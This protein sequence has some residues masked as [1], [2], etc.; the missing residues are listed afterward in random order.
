MTHPLLIPPHESEPK[1][2]ADSPPSAPSAPKPASGTSEPAEAWDRVRVIQSLA[3]AAARSREAEVDQFALIAAAADVYAWVDNAEEA[4][5]VYGG[6]SPRAIHGERLWQFGA[7]GTPEVAE[8]ITFE[9]GPAL[10]TSPESAATLIADVLDL[11]H[12]FPRTWQLVLQGRVLGWLAR[13]IAQNT[14]RA[15]LSRELA[16]ELDRHIAPFIEGWTAHQTLIRVAMLIARLDPE[17]AE[18]RRRQELAARFVAITQGEAGTAVLHGQL[19]GPAGRA[20]DQTLNDL[21]DVL[22]AAGL[23][24]S[25]DELR[26]AA[27]EALADP[28]YAA[29]LL[30]GTI[31]HLSDP[32][33]TGPTD[34]GPTDP[35]PTGST[36]PVPGPRPDTGL[37]SPWRIGTLNLDLHL[38]LADLILGAGGTA[39]QLGEVARSQIDELI[40]RADKV[41]ITPVLDPYAPD[42]VE[43]Y[44]IPDRIA[45]AVKLRNPTVV[46]PFSN[47]AST[48]AHVQVDHVIPHPD[49]PTHTD[50]LAPE[51]TKAHR[52]KTFGGY[53]TTTIR[54]GT[55]HW[56]T[57]TGQQ[58]WVTPH[59]TYRADPDTPPPRAFLRLSDRARRAL[60]DEDAHADNDSHARRDS[61]PPQDRVRDGLPPHTLHPEPIPNPDPRPQWNGTMT[62]P[63]GGWPAVDPDA[64]PPF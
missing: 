5:E 35:S 33:D 61:A 55:Y 19:D 6:G 31:A 39:S 10:G 38:T 11:R 37:G 62:P 56:V 64:P 2:A 23:D 44:E 30:H 28:M 25:R 14:R 34:T 48:S 50:N 4:A 58:F 51:S 1:S 16:H 54:P 8:F 17:G 42:G 21:A 20:L 24:G 36:G 7:D 60:L 45:R 47:R 26:A 9:V 29:D 57:P 41:V 46:F 52:A 49:G 15:G 43:G 18:E 59:G 13:R 40:A 22:D 12:R 63:G 3:A 32:T 53:R 27:L